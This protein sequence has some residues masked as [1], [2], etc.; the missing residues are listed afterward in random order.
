[1]NSQ[2]K[3]ALFE[4]YIEKVYRLLLDLETSKDDEPVMISRNVKLLRNGY[5]DEIDIYYE[6]TKAKIRHKVAIECKNY[7]SP[8]EIG[9]IRD[10]HGKISR[11]QNITGVFISNNGF[12]TGAK[13]YAI[14]H[15]IIL[16]VTSELP[17]FFN[18][19]G[20]R[21]GQVYLPDEYTKGEPFYVLMEM[22]NRVLTGSYHVIKFND[23]PRSI[24][25]FLSKKLAVEYIEKT[26]EFDLVP[27]GLKQESY[28]FL[29]YF[30]KK[31]D[32]KF[33]LNIMHVPE[34]ENVVS[35]FIEPDQLKSEYS[36]YKY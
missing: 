27:R 10:F 4:E 32:L 9:K 28:D 3:G 6:F 18:L 26:K 16:M 21:I 33:Q 34:S 13:N 7:S 23:T 14:E 19:I 17:N 31:M 11:S 1:M 5:T 2:D 12:Q 30:A 24:I 20:K 35:F 29:V 8:V 25:L 15:G 22:Q 36:D